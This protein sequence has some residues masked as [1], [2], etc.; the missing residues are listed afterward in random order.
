MRL[1]ATDGELWNCTRPEY[2]AYKAL[3][4]SSFRQFIFDGPADYY[5]WHVDPAPERTVSDDMLFGQYFHSL[6]L[7]R[8]ITWHVAEQCSAT[9]ESK[10]SENYGERCPH[11]GIVKVGNEWFCG[12]HSK[13]PPTPHV[14]TE[15]L[16][17]QL[18]SMIGS[19]D[20]HDEASELINRSGYEEHGIKFKLD[21]IPCKALLD[22]LQHDL[23]IVDLKTIR[24]HSEWLIRRALYGETAKESYYVQAAWYT[25]ARE[26]VFPGTNAP[27]VFVFVS[28][29]PPHPTICVELP[30][31]AIL[32]GKRK[33]AQALD[34]FKRCW[35]EKKWEHRF[36]SGR[37]VIP[38]P[39]GWQDEHRVAWEEI[40]L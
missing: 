11:P 23:T 7:E 30:E 3:R 16:D 9:I 28:K 27:F 14:L 17:R 2:Q 4:S 12:R 1:K 25:L 18:R 38:P 22:R 8:E 40:D 20:A 15:D 6:A 32:A 26:A 31:E 13:Q 33:I 10:R 39:S 21:G 34:E 5:F 37:V 19:I 35:R 29:Q 24:G 36:G